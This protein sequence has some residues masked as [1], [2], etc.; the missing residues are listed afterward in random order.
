MQN[1]STD[2]ALNEPQ[3]VF[4]DRRYTSPSSGNIPCNDPTGSTTDSEHAWKSQS[5][6]S[7]QYLQSIVTIHN[8]AVLY[9]GSLRR[10]SVPHTL[11]YNDRRNDKIIQPNIT[12]D[13]IRLRALTI[14][15]EEQTESIIKQLLAQI[16]L[17]LLKNYAFAL[18]TLSNFLSSLGFFCSI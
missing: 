18:F 4:D 14:Q 12:N 1:T 3:R 17:K 10:M 8:N 9:K 15:G 6:Q 11:V 7:T 2:T 5:Q 16:N 13:D